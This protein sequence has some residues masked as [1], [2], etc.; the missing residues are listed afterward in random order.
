MLSGD[1]P[2][3]QSLGIYR[4]AVNNIHLSVVTVVAGETWILCSGMQS[5]NSTVAVRDISNTAA[6]TKL[7]L[8]IEVHVTT[9]A[10]SPPLP[11]R[12]L[13]SSRSS[14]LPT[15]SHGLGVSLVNLPWSLGV[16][17]SRRDA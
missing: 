15:I 5:I 12:G 14:T 13:G 3:Q 17:R 4:T 6:L 16:M 7:Q 9:A 10:L 1:E 11:A 8:D 2:E